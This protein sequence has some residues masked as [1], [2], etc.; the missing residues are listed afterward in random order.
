MYYYKSATADTV[1][2]L[3]ILLFS[4]TVLLQFQGKAV[5]ALPGSSCQRW[6]GDVEII[7]PFGIG[8][9]CAMKGFELDCNK[10]EDGRSIL[11]FFGEIPVLNISVLNGQFRI[12]KHVSTIFYH[13]NSR[14]VDTDYW[15]QDL[16]NTPFTYSW[17]SNMFTVI[18]V[19]TL[20][21]MT[22]NTVSIRFTYNKN[23]YVQRLYVASYFL[24]CQ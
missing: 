24:G 14:K 13:L 3:L 12:M 17:K 4:L 21:C 5:V 10:T 8:A 18:G 7:Y 9:G 6:C 1:P 20:A 22:D 23:Y 19:N 15:G 11:T 2:M 16:S